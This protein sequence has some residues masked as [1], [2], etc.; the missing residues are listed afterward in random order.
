MATDTA[1]SPSAVQPGK[2]PMTL[3]AAAD[4]IEAV[5]LKGV[6]TPKALKPAAWIDPDTSSAEGRGFLNSVLGEVIQRGPLQG[7]IYG[8]QEKQRYYKSALNVLMPAVEKAAQAWAIAT[9]ARQQTKVGSLLIVSNSL[10]PDLHTAAKTAQTRA[11]TD[12]LP[13]T[14]LEEHAEITGKTR[15]RSTLVTRLQRVQYMRA[16]RNGGNKYLFYLMVH[17]RG[18]KLVDHFAES[19]DDG[20]EYATETINECLDAISETR[21]DLLEDE[22]LAWSFPPAIAGGVRALGLGG[23]PAIT[24]FA[25]AWAAVKRG[26]VD[27]ALELAGNAILVLDLAGPV[28]AA[29]GEV[30]NFVLAAIGTAVSF[31]RDLEQDQAAMASGFADEAEKL[32]EGSRGI[33]TLLQGAATIVA[34]LGLPGTLRRVTSESKAATELVAAAERAPPVA[35]V[36][37]RGLPVQRAE[38]K[39]IAEAERGAGSTATVKAMS[40]AERGPGTVATVKAMSEAE[41][42][43]GSVATVKAM[44]EAER[45]VGAR[46]ATAEAK[47]LSP[48]AKS[49]PAEAGALEARGAAPE[50]TSVA[51]QSKT[52]PADKQAGKGT[53]KKEPAKERARP[54][55]EADP[56]SVPRDPEAP[57]EPSARPTALEGKPDAVLPAELRKEQRRALEKQIDAVMRE[58]A[59]FLA[60][61]RTSQAKLKDINA[62]LS[63]AERSGRTQEAALLRTERNAVLEDLDQLGALPESPEVL[64]RRMRERRPRENPAQVFVDEIEELKRALA[65]TQ[66]DYFEALSK[67]A[68][69]RDAYTAVRSRGIDE[70][71]GSKGALEVEHLYPRSK[72][73]AIPGFEKLDWDVQAAIFNYEPNLRL[74]SKEAN[75]TRGNRPYA[76]LPQSF[77]SKFVSDER[78]IPS[79]SYQLAADERLMEERIRRMIKDPNYRRQQ[80]GL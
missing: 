53:R 52:R 39:A 4:L 15:H 9:L 42:G 60:E 44:S 78:V 47:A 16:V 76:S 63:A 69:R 17:P 38:G 66:A 46:G 73:F 29:V 28:G 77:W 32:S 31:L 8:V 41:R 19:A 10:A 7:Y 56:R 48:E 25:L 26:R 22:E 64:R 37:A 68:S 67:S 35:E 61:I 27:S 71:F 79:V 1:R 20:R 57:R 72:I 40:E 59:E 21:I 5:Y 74:M 12:V 62:K 11:R 51:P 65:G 6:A 49:V 43:P 33:G 34:A 55:E 30:L 13:E 58:K 80:V 23:R 45:E 50:A 2:G 24:K 36:N 14:T 18:V 75:G 54:P 3:T 70:V